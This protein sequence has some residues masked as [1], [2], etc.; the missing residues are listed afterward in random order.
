MQRTLILIAVTLF[1]AGALALSLAN[2]SQA[3][4]PVRKPNIILIL[5]DD[6]DTKIH[7]FMP[8]TKALLEDQGV[9]L[10]N[11]FVTYALCCPSRSSL[12]RGQY[13]HNTKV[14]GNMLPQGGYQKFAQQGL[15]AST[16]GTWLE[17]AG[18]RT[19]FM[20][21]YLNG[22]GNRGTDPAHVPAGWSEWYGAIGNA[23]YQD[24]N[25]DLNENGKTV[26][27][28]NAP[29]DYLTD[30]ISGKAADAIKRAAQDGKPFLL[31][32]APFTP[33]SP[34]NFAPRHANLFND[35]KL[36]RPPSWNEADVSDK[37]VSIRNRAVLTD[38]QIAQMQALY[39]KRLKSL[40]AIDDLIENLVKTLQGTNQLENTYIVYTSDNGFH[41]GEHR[42]PQGKNTAFEE[43][44]RVPFVVRGP[45]VPA[46]KKLEPMALNIDLAPT[47]AEIAGI[48]TPEFV[49]GRSL[50][51]LVRSGNAPKP[52][53][54]SFM[55]ER[56]GGPGAQRED[57]D[58]PD[59]QGA[60]EFNA[61][62]T[63][64]WTYAEYGNNERE[65]YD[66]KRDPYQL[67][68]I[69]AKADPALVKALSARLA[70]LAA[71]KASACR[72]A[73]DLPKP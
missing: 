57:G 64:D 22:Y 8:K 59:P 23:P 32:L 60:L 5:S 66:L 61:I 52:W 19:V 25:Y 71:C 21:K 36:P 4:S 58:A 33:H 34:A 50:L 47:F 53:R 10:S 27:Y 31:Y 73:E 46:A 63:A 30:V 15:E 37:P 67:E 42:L 62:R 9:T 2:R 6:E 12:L 54:S 17:G 40:Q 3:Q 16:I 20:G 65:L 69:A 44:I 68:N 28:G 45:G 48:K 26:H 38:R 43:D 39:V 18:Y 49:D 1:G 11:Y 13:P 72:Q 41:M 51:P 14:E 7:A 29:G 55:I 35:A 70:A 56:R 24:F